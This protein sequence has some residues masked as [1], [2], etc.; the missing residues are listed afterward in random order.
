MTQ[1]LLLAL[2]ADGL[3]SLMDAIIKSMTDR[4]PT[5]VIAFLR[6]ASGTFWSSLLLCAARPG[7]PSRETAM[8]NATRSVLVVMT[9]TAFFYA[10]GQLPLAEVVALS[11]LS[12]LFIALFGVL[13]LAEKIDRRILIA[14]ASGFLG[15]LLI[16]GG[17]L[18]SGTYGSGALYGVAA[19]IVS[20]VC[21]A[22][23][24]V[25]LRARAQRDS[26]PVIVW[27]QNCGP[28]LFLAPAAALVW[29]MPTLADFGL[30][31]L[32]GLIGVTGHYLLANA[33]A[34]AEA[35]RL[36]PVH[37]TTLI[38]GAAFGYFV[39]SEVPGLSTWL[40]AGLIVVGTLFT[41]PPRK[42][43]DRSSEAAAS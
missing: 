33:F 39:F 2:V 19:C 6:F 41:R 23:A 9:A 10:L 37:Y 36:A 29:V 12:P 3:L 28:A 21:Y 42:A 26:L 17:K 15:M 40:G 43:A 22:L 35:A 1:A 7:W 34:R 18:G 8:Y 5:F 25:L 27:F 14:L 31:A 16:A 32:I 11:F 38:W 13:F 4:Y 24:L 30:F 20:A